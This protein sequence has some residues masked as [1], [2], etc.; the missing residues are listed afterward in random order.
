MSAGLVVDPGGVEIENLNCWY[1]SF[2][3]IHGVTTRFERGRITA[4][5]GPSG[6]GKTTLLRCLNRVH[7]RNPAARTTGSIRILGQDILAPDVCVRELRRQVG[8][9]FQ[10]P[11]PLPLSI[12]ENVAFGLRIHG[13]SERNGHGAVDSAVESALR[14]VGLWDAVRDRLHR[15]AVELSLEQQQRLCFARLLP[16]KPSV[17]LLDEPCSALDAAGTEAL[18]VLMRRLCPGRVV[19]LVTHSLAQAR[20]V[21]DDTAYLLLGKLIE[22]GASAEVFHHPRDP[23]TAQYLG[24]HYG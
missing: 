5:V 6:C 3:A 12:F 18:E 21:S 14:D 4:L 10:R 9:V 16:L 2:Q 23:R 19:V 17:L 11:N 20:R 13:G 1:G 8:M 15:P 22:Q 24:G 7:E